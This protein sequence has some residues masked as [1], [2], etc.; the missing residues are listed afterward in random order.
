MTT[1]APCACPLYRSTQG[2]SSFHAPGGLGIRVESAVVAGSAV[3]VQYDPLI[4]KVI[5]H[6]ATRE[7]AI[8]RMQTAL[9]ELIVDGIETNVPLHRR[10]L[11]DPEFLQGAV[12]TRYLEKYE[13]QP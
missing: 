8:A 3:P 11:A 6:G 1:S 10:I 12:H 4:A 9:D 7:Q 13:G 2:R 5:A